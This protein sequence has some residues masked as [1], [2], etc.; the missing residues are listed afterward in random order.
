M[1]ILISPLYGFSS[2]ITCVTKIGIDKLV[3]LVDDKIKEK[4]KESLDMINKTFE[5]VLEI[6]TV[7]INMYDVTRI[8]ETV[9]TILDGFSDKDTIYLDVTSG[10]KTIAFGVLFGAFTR[11]NRIKKIV[12]VTEET[13]QIVTLP[14]LSYQLSE[15]QRKVIDYIHKNQI[16]SMDDFANKIG[17]SKPM[18]YK[19]IKDLKERNIL[20][21]S[22]TGLKLTDTGRIVSL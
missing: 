4:Q 22:E 11:I 13:K 7:K 14:K 6:E 1:R 10:R 5:H 16:I 3:L 9:V 12:Y 19:N 21:E 20:Y 2:I 18:L 17:V 15:S 8:A